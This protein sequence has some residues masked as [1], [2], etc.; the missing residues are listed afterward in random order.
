[1]RKLIS[2]LGIC[3]F[4]ILGSV[5][6]VSC[7]DDEETLVIPATPTAN[8]LFED[9]WTFA[10]NGETLKLG[11]ISIDES[12]SSSGIYIDRVDFFFDGN[13]IASSTVAPFSLGY[14][15]KGQSIGEHEL[16][17][18][19]YVKGEGY[20]DMTYT[21]DIKVTVLEEPFALNFV[22]SYDN[23]AHA[24]SEIRNG[25]T[26]S[27]SVAI[28]DAT[29]ID[30]SITKAEYYWD[31]VMFGAT[32]IPPYRFSF[33]I[34]NQPLGEHEFKLVISVSSSLGNLT[35][36]NTVRFNVVG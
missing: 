26:L 22:L 10:A 16:K 8:F 18:K 5:S 23:A 17:L 4:G 20:T 31:G 27:G 21:F 9:L 29:T 3:L 2:F 19:I 24:N 1:M 34:E 32:S 35:S 14:L 25:E 13:P 15:L 36:T 11:G 12:K 6:L 7:S 28:S 33:P 30:A